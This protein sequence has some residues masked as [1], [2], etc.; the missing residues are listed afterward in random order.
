MKK[1]PKDKFNYVVLGSIIGVIFGVVLLG[2]F[3]LIYKSG[4]IGKIRSKMDA[5][6]PAG[7]SHNKFNFSFED[8]N[9]VT[10]FQG[11]DGATLKVVDEHATDGRRSLLVEYPTGNEF[12]GLEMEV[13]GR[14]CFSWADKEF[15]SADIFNGSDHPNTLTVKIKSGKDY[16]KRS[17]EREYV[18]APR[19]NTTI[20]ILISEMQKA[21]DVRLISYLNF[22]LHSPAQKVSLY[23]D[24]IKVGGKGEE[25]P[26]SSA[27]TSAAGESQAVVD[28]PVQLDQPIVLDVYPAEDVRPINKMIY[29]SNL[30]SKVEFEMDVAK[31]AKDMGITNFRFPGGGSTGYHWKLSK[32]EFEARF[33]TAPLSNMENVLKFAEIAGAQMIIQVNVESGTPQEAA[34]WVE[35]MNKKSGHRVDYWE[36]GN[37][38]YGDWDK[39]YMSGEKY[40]DVVKEY[41]A[42]M[43]AVDPAIKIGADFGGP[44]YEE[45]DVA[46]L[47]NA[48]DSIDFVSYHWYPNHINPDKKYKGRSHPLPEE[49]MANALAIPQIINRFEGLVKNYAPQRTGQIEFT[50]LEWDGSWDAVSSDLDFQYKGVMWSLANAIFYAD[51]LG[52]MALNGIS[53]SSIYTLEEVM[54]GLIRGWDKDA[55]WG[56]SPWDR[57]SVRPKAFAIK[58]FSRYFGDKLI[59][60]NLQGSPSYYKEQDWSSSSFAGNVP[61]VAAYTSRFTSEDTVAIILINKH[62]SQDFPVT[63]NLKNFVP[64]DTGDAWILMGP[65]LLAQNDGKPGTVKLRKFAVKDV[66]DSFVFISPAHSVSVMQIRKGS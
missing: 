14:D 12:P 19:Q 41:A 3:M 53:A 47:T 51:A 8:K 33:D 65:D 35:Y 34:E 39:A 55:G 64:A 40:A 18:L 42:A 36:I 23:F 43:K 1:L 57:E 17:F 59:K 60:N 10:V 7:T 44:S 63:I 30:D 46:T 54:F 31:F 25:A 29:G 13:F 4:L 62:A 20:N 5:V 52:Q 15:F 11:N 50:F 24:N 58:I 28:Q 48:G 2:M 38:V 9:S 26:A 61:Y 6:L 66:K 37:E 45:F 56:G 16:P 32:H 27:D 49:I 21:L 22:F